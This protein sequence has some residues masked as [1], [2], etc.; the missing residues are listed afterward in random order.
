MRLILFC[1]FGCLVLGVRKA[2]AQFTSITLSG[3]VKDK[4]TKTLLSY[5]SV[6]LKSTKDSAFV[7]GTITAEN[8][9]FI[10]SGVKPGNYLLQVSLTGYVAKWKPLFAGSLSQ[11]LDLAVVELEQDNKALEGVLMKE[12]FPKK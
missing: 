9:S 2:D 11:F 1:F 4:T 6:E 3:E 8:G 12:T 7:A 10:I 5:A